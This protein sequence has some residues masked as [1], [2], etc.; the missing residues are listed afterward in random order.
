MTPI[1]ASAPPR[2]RINAQGNNMQTLD[3]LLP[4]L[5]EAERVV[6]EAYPVQSYY[7]YAPKEI[8]E[9]LV[10]MRD[11]LPL[12]ISGVFVIPESLVDEKHKNSVV[13]AP[14]STIY[15]PFG[16]DEPPKCERLL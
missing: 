1:G 5:R 4:Q 15:S 10:N 16:F 12:Y 9:Q 7:I 2:M 14:K 8:A 6:K 11:D 3:E 13:V